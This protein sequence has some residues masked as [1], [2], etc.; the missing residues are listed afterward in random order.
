M[1]FEF[2]VIFIKTFSNF[3][4]MV[5]FWK[6]DTGRGKSEYLKLMQRNGKSYSLSLD[7]IHF[8]GHLYGASL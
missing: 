7:V 1:L 4:L 8:E 3:L 5:S 6:K 2:S